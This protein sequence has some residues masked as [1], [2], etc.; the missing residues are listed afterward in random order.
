MCRKVHCLAAVPRKALFGEDLGAKAAAAASIVLEQ[1]PEQRLSA[2]QATQQTG[3][4][5]YCTQEPTVVEGASERSATAPR[6]S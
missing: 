2:R 3:S 6:A 5:N 4:V 1:P